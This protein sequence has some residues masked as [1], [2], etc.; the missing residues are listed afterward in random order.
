MVALATQATETRAVIAFDIRPS[1]GSRRTLA[2]QIHPSARSLMR[3]L[4]ADGL[5]GVARAAYLPIDGQAAYGCLYFNARDIGIGLVMHEIG[6]AAMDW[7]RGVK[8]MNPAAVVPGI[9]ASPDEELLCDTIENL[10]S[11]FANQAFKRGIW[12]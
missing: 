12:R 11:Q 6:H 2:V 8:G 3:Q 7:V 10:A 4:H 9:Y 1:R 5:P